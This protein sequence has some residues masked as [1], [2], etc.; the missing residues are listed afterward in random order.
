LRFLPRTPDDCENDYENESANDNDS[1]T[2]ASLPMDLTR[3]RVHILDD[4]DGWTRAVAHSL[5]ERVAR[6]LAGQQHFTLALTGGSTPRAM[7][8]LLGREPLRSNV[9][10]D[11]VRIFFGDE[12]AVP[13]DHADSNYRMASQAWLAS[14]TLAPEA[15]FRMEGEA[16]DLEEA[17]RRYEAVVRREV[18]A[19]DDGWPRFDLIL[20]GMGEDG[21]TASLFPGTRALD[22]TRRAVVANDV[23]QLATRRL[24]LTLPALN[25]AREIWL[26]ATGS[27]KARRVAETLGGREGG[28]SLPIARVR[29]AHGELH[30]WLDRAAAAA[31]PADLRA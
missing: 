25:A 15:I 11:R 7:Y 17:A 23:P 22:E 10:W 27:A 14:S 20:L 3:P 2:W 26:L 29:P 31:L 8:G 24:T 16:E 6:R 28:E 21:H 13:P 30:W 19:D 1:K 4:P 5:A 9:D 12:R 18:P